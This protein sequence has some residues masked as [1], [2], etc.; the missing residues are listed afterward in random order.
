MPQLTT[1]F[2]DALSNAEPTDDDKSNAP[3]AHMEVREV[4]MADRTLSGWGLDPIL[5][6]SAISG[7]S[8]FAG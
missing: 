7:T 4:L 8:A 6:G 1:Q 2:K 5:I 3:A